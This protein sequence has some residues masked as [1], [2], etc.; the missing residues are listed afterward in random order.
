VGSKE[1][2]SRLLLGML[3]VGMAVVGTAGCHLAVHKQED[4]RPGMH[5][6]VHPY[7]LSQVVALLLQ[8]YKVEPLIPSEGVGDELTLL[9]SQTDL[10]YRVVARMV[11]SP[12]K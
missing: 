10:G 7:P 4:T 11:S 6:Q 1:L 8:S 12:A 2:A 3:V 5:M 9:A